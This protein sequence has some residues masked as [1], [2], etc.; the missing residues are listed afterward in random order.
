ME[1]SSANPW[2]KHFN[3]M[4][5]GGIPYRKKMYTVAPQVGSGDIKIVTP[6]QAVVDRAKMDVKRKLKEASV[7]KPKRVKVVT[8]SGAG[9]RKKNNNKVKKNRKGNNNSKSKPKK[10][11]KQAKKSSAS[12]KK[13]GKKGKAKKN[14]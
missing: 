2:V 10:K 6:T 12:S 5:Q 1:T 11:K 8:Q 14:K 3:D 7:Y 13:S 4:A 9:R